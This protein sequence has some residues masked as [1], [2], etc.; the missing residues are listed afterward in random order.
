MN[1]KRAFAKLIR[2][3]VG[4]EPLIFKGKLADDTYGPLPIDDQYRRAW[5]RTGDVLKAMQEHGWERVTDDDD[6]EPSTDVEPSSPKVETVRDGASQEAAQ[7]VIGWIQN[8]LRPKVEGRKDPATGEAFDQ[9]G[10][11]P[12]ENAA[13]MLT[14]GIGVDAIKHALT[15]HYP[16]DLRTEL[17]VRPFDPTTFA[18]A[19]WGPVTVPAN[20]AAHSGRHKALPYVAALADAGVPI[21]LIGPPGTGKTTLAKHLAEDHYGHG[22]DAERFGFVSMT[23]ATAPSAFQGRPKVA[24]DG[25]DALV[26]A[27]IA[28]GD[29]KQA[30]QIAQAKHAEADVMIAQFERIFTG[31]G[32]WLFDEMDA[33]DPSLMLI[34]NAALANRKFSNPTTGKTVDAAPDWVPVAGMNTLGLG[35]DRKMVA[36]GKQDA[37]ALDR[38]NAGRVEILLDTDLERA[39]FWREVQI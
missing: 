22:P 7:N 12:A 2:P 26:S 11:R 18:P 37:A 25:T 31:G 32:V 19:Q 3:L 5:Y 34:V 14:R 17:G 28:T 16:A 36:R 1:R 39:I 6:P 9:I 29:A 4:S 30:L 10:L 38:W 35:G 23:R 20:V 13:R 21:A 24:D 8:T 27:L 15:L 33:A